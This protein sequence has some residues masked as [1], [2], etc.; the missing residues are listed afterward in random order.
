[1]TVQNS[2]ILKGRWQSGDFS[3]SN[4]CDDIYLEQQVQIYAEQV[5]QFQLPVAK[6]IS[7]SEKKYFKILKFLIVRALASGG[8]GQPVFKTCRG[9][10]LVCKKNDCAVVTHLA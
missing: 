3:N 6:E 9:G 4:P 1:M 10:F 5:Q 7:D 2:I 8:M